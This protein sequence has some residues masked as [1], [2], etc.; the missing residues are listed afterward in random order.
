[1]HSSGGFVSSASDDAIM[2]Q[3]FVLFSGTEHFPL[4]SSSDFQDKK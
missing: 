4:K 2:Q 3:K 1:M